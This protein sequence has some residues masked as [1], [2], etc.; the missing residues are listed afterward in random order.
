VRALLVGLTYLPAKGQTITATIPFG[1]GPQALALN[2]TTNKIY[3]A[4]AGANNVAVI[5]GATN[6][7]TFVAARGKG[8]KRRPLPF[9]SPIPAQTGDGAERVCR[10]LI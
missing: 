9:R 1:S 5:D 3:V 7:V 6:G 8:L 2:P 10:F 4:R